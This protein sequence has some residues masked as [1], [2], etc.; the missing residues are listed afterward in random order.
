MLRSPQALLCAR[1]ASREQGPHRTTGRTPARRRTPL[2]NLRALDLPTGGLS[3]WNRTARST[4]HSPA[5]R[6]A[7][8][9]PRASG[10]TAK[11][12]S[13]SRFCLLVVGRRGVQLDVHHVRVVRG[14]SCLHSRQG[15]CDLL[16]ELLDVVARLR[17]GL[18]EHDPVRARLVLALLDGNRPPVRHVRLVSH[19]HDQH[20]VAALIAH[21]LDPLGCVQ[22]RRTIGDVVHYHGHGGVPDVAG[23]EAAEALL[24][25]GIPQLQAHCAVVQV[26]GLGQEV[27]A[28]CGLIVLVEIVVHEPR[29]DRGLP[30]I[31]VTQEHELVLRERRDRRTSHASRCGFSGRHCSLDTSAWKALPDGDARERPRV[32]F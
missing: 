30:H 12:T 15:D 19:E 9:R 25:S 29:D 21:I 18:H 31:L 28:N 7:H 6:R 13:T 20:V 17:A 2:Q 10:A 11:L 22:K 4:F 5:C 8:L 23:D 3:T 14:R 26:H 32:L 1:W 24:T 27:D 16:E